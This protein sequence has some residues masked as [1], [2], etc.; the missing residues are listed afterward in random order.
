NLDRPQDSFARDFLAHTE[1]GQVFGSS[2]PNSQR[3]VLENNPV[4]SALRAFQ[5]IV[6][7]LGTA[8]VDGAQLRSQMKRNRWPAK[9][10]LKHRR[11]QML[12]GV[13][14]HVIEAARPVDTAQNVRIAGLS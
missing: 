5:N 9:T 13:L 1:L 11:E 4:G 14:L 8:Q 10:F 3:T 7:R 12:P 6:R 2:I